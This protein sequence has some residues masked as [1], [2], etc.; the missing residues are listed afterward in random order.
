LPVL[1]RKAAAIEEQIAQE[2]A[3][4]ANDTG[5][6]AKRIAN[7]ERLSL[8]RE[9]ANRMTSAT[10]AEL[11]RARTEASRQMLYLERIV[12]PNLADFSTEPKRIRLVSTV[13]AANVLLLLIG[14]LIYSGVREHAP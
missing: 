5:G 10:E 12:E 7:Y 8:E 14:W 9:F 3:R 4:I 11:V 13:F 1:Q 6:L 2:R